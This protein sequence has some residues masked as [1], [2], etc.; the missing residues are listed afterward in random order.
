MAGFRVAHVQRE[1][2]PTQRPPKRKKYLEFLHD[3][4]CV[5]TGRY[6]VQAA[7]VS[8]ASPMHGHYGRAK[9]TKAP[10]RFAL[11][12]CPGE[13]ARQHDMNE[14]E[15]WLS[16]G[17]DPHDLANTLWGIFCDFQDNPS[18]AVARCTSRINQGLAA[19]DRLKSRDTL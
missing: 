11:P 10:D 2:A 15:F 1:E 19:A 14:R 4:P 18:L 5:V 3:L 13:H 12:L 8:Y 17:I 9:G 7:H 6:G 16:V